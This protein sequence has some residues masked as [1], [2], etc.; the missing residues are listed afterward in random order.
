MYERHADES[1]H[2]KIPIKETGV[3]TL[4]TKFAEVTINFLFFKKG[5]SYILIMQINEFF[6]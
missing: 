1:F 4:I 3:Y 6:I 5:F 2:Y